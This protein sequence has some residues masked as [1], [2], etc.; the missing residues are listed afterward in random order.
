MWVFCNCLIVNPTFDSQTK[1]NMTLNVKQFGSKFSLSDKFANQ[2]VKSGIVESVLAWSKFKADLQLK[3]K[4]SG[5]KT[6]KLKGIPKLEVS[7]NQLVMLVVH[8]T[9]RIIH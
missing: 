9:F 4:Q 7:Y 5:K 1:E 6:N 2:L 8:E 3:S